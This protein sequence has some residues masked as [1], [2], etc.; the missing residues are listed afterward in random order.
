MAEQLKP[1]AIFVTFTK[2]LVTKGIIISYYID[3]HIMILMSIT[4]FHL[5]FTFFSDTVLIK[6][7]NLYKT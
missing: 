5:P 3:L 2:G 7:E 6:K 1:G 4:I